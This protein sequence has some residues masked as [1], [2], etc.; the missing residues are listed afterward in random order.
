MTFYVWSILY[1][2]EVAEPFGS[3]G[4]ISR[5]GVERPAWQEWVGQRPSDQR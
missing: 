1:D 5:S 4:M 2:Q 3:M